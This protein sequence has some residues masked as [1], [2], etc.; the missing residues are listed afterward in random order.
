[1]LV[2]TSI[3]SPESDGVLPPLRKLSQAR[4]QTAFT[5]A[6]F[7][8]LPRPDSKKLQSATAFIIKW[9]CCNGK[10]K[11][12][13]N[14]CGIISRYVLHGFFIGESRYSSFLNWNLCLSLPYHQRS[15]DLH[16]NG[17]PSSW[18]LVSPNSFLGCV[19]VRGSRLLGEDAMGQDRD[20]FLFARRAEEKCS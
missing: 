9:I 8:G 17:F 14:I 2:L 19:D 1:M 3:W 6:A 18:F 16:F 12:G 11:T 15:L 13:K 4:I 7:W 10:S 20:A 5:K